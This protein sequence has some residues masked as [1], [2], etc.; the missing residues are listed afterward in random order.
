M[1]PWVDIDVAA[2]TQTLDAPEHSNQ[3]DVYETAHTPSEGSADDLGPV[4]AFVA[5][6][7]ELIRSDAYY[8][9]IAVAVLLILVLGVALLV[10]SP[11]G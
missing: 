4:G 8:R 6:I 7:V 5:R 2:P 11:K 10:F 1:G 3:R 9:F